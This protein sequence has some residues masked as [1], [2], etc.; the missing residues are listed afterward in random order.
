MTG[1]AYI[2]LLNVEVLNDGAVTAHTMPCQTC[3]ITFSSY[4]T[5]VRHYTEGARHYGNVAA[6]SWFVL[7]VAT[8]M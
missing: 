1:H 3:M 5:V 6:V 2:L 8:E 7:N 4:V